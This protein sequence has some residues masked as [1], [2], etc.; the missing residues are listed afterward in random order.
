MREK[1][2]AALNQ[3]KED[4]TYLVYHFSPKGTFRT[5]HYPKSFVV[6]LVNENKEVSIHPDFDDIIMIGETG[7]SLRS[8]E[9]NIYYETLDTEGYLEYISKYNPYYKIYIRLD[10]E[11]K[12]IEF[13]LGDKY[14][15]LELIEEGWD[16]YVSKPYRQKYMKCVSAEDLEKHIHDEFWNPRMVEIGRRVLKIKSIF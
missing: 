13:K 6:E 14:K 9:Q 8:F 4:A 3:T 15:K 7:V 1:L 11:N 2:V 16:G 10:K 5:K 12:T